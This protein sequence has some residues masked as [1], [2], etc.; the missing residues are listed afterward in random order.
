[1][2]SAVRN[3]PLKSIAHSSFGAC[4]GDHHLTLGQR[5]AAA[6]GV[7]SIR[8]CALQD[9]ADRRGRRPGRYQDGLAVSRARTFFGP[10]RGKRSRIADDG[11]AILGRRRVRAAARRPAQILEPAR[12][13]R[14]SRRRFHRIERLPADPV[15]D[16][17]ARQR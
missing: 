9:V 12:R 15:T 11:R 6:A 13:R 3:Q 4:A 14:L 16:G 5:H 2:P 17:T 1:M 10:K 8:P 7:A